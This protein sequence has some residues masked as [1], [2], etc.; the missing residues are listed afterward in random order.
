MRLGEEKTTRNKPQ[1]KNIL[2]AS[3]T[4]GD[5]KNITCFHEIPVSVFANEINVNGGGGEGTTEAATVLGGDSPGQVS[6]ITSTST[7]IY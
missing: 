4:Q 1:G 7:S 6:Y 3:A 2:S 5:H